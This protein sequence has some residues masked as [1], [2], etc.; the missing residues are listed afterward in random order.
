MGGLVL[1][2]S[3]LR[4]ITKSLV[5]LQSGYKFNRLA[6]REDIG[7]IPVKSEFIGKSKGYIAST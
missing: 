6:T 5:W 3:W 4:Q 2:T 1:A 7:T